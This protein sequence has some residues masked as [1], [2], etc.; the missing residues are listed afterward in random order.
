MH[1][2]PARRPGIRAPFPD[3]WIMGAA[4]AAP[5]DR[6]G[7]RRC[8]SGS[9]PKLSASRKTSSRVLT[10]QGKPAEFHG[11]VRFPGSIPAERS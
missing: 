6:Q 5:D 10:I 11:G 4:F 2:L 9:G 3:G 7:V 1:T 8:I